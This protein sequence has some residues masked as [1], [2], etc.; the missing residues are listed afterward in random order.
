[1]GTLPFHIHFTG[2]RRRFHLITR[3]AIDTT[4]FTKN[5]IE[6]FDELSWLAIG[7]SLLG[8]TLVSFLIMFVYQKVC[9]Q[10]T[11]PY[12]TKTDVFLKICFGFTEPERLFITHPR[13]F[14]V[15]N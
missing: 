12:L 2:Q 5:V 3:H 14:T 11:L 7:L 6:P 1:M 15:G 8:L 10:N 9:P 13:S 4:D